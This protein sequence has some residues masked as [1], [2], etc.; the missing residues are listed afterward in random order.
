[1][2]RKRTRDGVL[3]GLSVAALLACAGPAEAPPLP[4]ERSPSGEPVTPVAG[5]SWLRHLGLE[6]SETRMGEMGGES[7]P[8]A[9][10]GREPEIA[11]AT[12]GEAGGAGMRGGMGMGGMMRRY[13]SSVRTDRERAREILSEPF[14]MTGEDLYRLDCR[15][16]HGPRGEGAPPEIKSL[17]DPVR[18]STVEGIDARMKAMN[19]SLPAG[20]AAKLAAEGEATIRKRLREGGKRMPPFAHLDDPEVDALLAYLRRLAGVAPA[21][22]GEGEVTESAA[23][24]GEHLVKGTCHVCHDATGPGSG[25]MSMMSG[26]IPSLAS[27]PREQALDAV[28]RQVAEGSSGM[29]AM[30]GGPRMPALPYLTD[31]EVAAAY[32]YLAEYPPRQ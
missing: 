19:R 5:P 7:G 22:A 30:M 9:S 16:C 28:E 25:H 13:L 32:F 10:A 6:V 2:T 29:M 3:I 21:D 24:V 26:T 4:P 31:D 23:R 1:M 15:S 17:I 18:A 12:A 27:F 8:P 11:D 14:T 20:M